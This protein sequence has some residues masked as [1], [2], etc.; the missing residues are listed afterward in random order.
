MLL[1]RHLINPDIKFI[2]VSDTGDQEYNY[3]DL[4]KLIDAYKNL[5][6]SCGC[7]PG[8]RAII[9]MPARIEQTAIVFA[10]AELAISI[11][12]VDYSRIDDWAESSYVDPKTKLLLP[13]DFFITESPHQSEVGPKYK[14]FDQICNQT[15]SLRI[16]NLDYTHNPTILATEDSEIIRCTSSG[17]T[18][19][20]KVIKH[21]HKFI[22]N[23]IV[24]NSRMFAG[25]AGL[26]RNLQHGSSFATYFLP[27]LASP[28]ITHFYNF[29]SQHTKEICLYKL[30][31]MM[32]PY[33]YLI[34]EFFESAVIKNSNLNIYTLSYIQQK[35][36]DYVRQGKAKNIISIFG[37]NETS[38]PIF[39][40]E[41]QPID[42]FNP[43]R[44]TKVDD[45]YSLS[46]DHDDV[47]TVSLPYYDSVNI[48]TNDRFNY[49]DGYYYHQGRSDLIRING[50]AV[51][52]LGYNEFAKNLLDCD[53]IYD[54][55]EHT[56]Y[57]AVW[58]QDRSEEQIQIIAKHLDTTTNGLHTISKW[59]FLEQSDF[60]RGVKIDH[61]LLR[62]YFRNYV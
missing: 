27:V 42:D 46:F 13:I 3:N 11:A 17:T 62:D 15:I 50:L 38:G 2:D 36:V 60:I 61:E 53:L 14:L 21:S 32:I 51:D 4:C 30:D 28:G 58:S 1:T 48:C 45:F 43:K 16:A 18:G 24:R 5:L 33:P 29:R 59:S 47:I 26:N 54:T 40:N 55:I 49:Q 25:K 56:I 44:F 23:L 52:L 6:Q 12:I 57:L 7:Q 35:W 8:Q 41:I 39:L 9:G 10:C 31:H 20:P 34:D 37:S 22:S 19:T